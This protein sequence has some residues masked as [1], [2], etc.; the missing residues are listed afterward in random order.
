[1]RYVMFTYVDPDRAAEWEAMSDEQ[2][3]AFIAEHEKWFAELAPRGVLAGGE[4]LSWPRKAATI[5]N[6]RGERMITD[7]PYAE[8]KDLLGGFIVLETDS[9]DEALGIAGTWPSLQNEGNKVELV[10]GLER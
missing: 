8:T 7:G 10:A 6:R 5:E 2:Q 3:K 1:M 9:W 4:E